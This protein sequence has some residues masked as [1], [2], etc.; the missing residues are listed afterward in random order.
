MTWNPISKIW[1]VIVV[2]VRE[3]IFNKTGA[4]AV[5]AVMGH[6]AEKRKECPS[7]EIRRK[8]EKR[9]KKKIG[10]AHPGSATS[11]ELSVPVPLIRNDPVAA[12]RKDI[13]SLHILAGKSISVEKKATP[14]ITKTELE[15]PFA[16]NSA[17]VTTP[18]IST[19]TTARSEESVE[20]E[21]D[22]HF[23]RRSRSAGPATA[24]A[25]ILSTETRWPRRNTVRSGTAADRRSRSAS[26]ILV[27]DA[28]APV[29]R[30]G[31]SGLKEFPRRTREDAKKLSQA[32][33]T[34]SRSCV[35]CAAHEGSRPPLTLQVNK[36]GNQSS[37]TPFRI[38]KFR[39]LDLPVTLLSFYIE[40][41]LNFLLPVD[42][43]PL[44][45][46][47]LSNHPSAFAVQNHSQQFFRELKISNSFPYKYVH[48]NY[49]ILPPHVRMHAHH[50][51]HSIFCLI[52][53][54]EC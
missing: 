36:S 20:V 1:L 15:A 2:T 48:D 44:R 38:P 35:K 51:T 32:T 28:P 25:A 22:N 27:T 19:S 9:V 29:S 46:R 3:F 11:T 23:R 53:A 41:R 30:K 45:V 6:G 49:Y 12:L 21:V 50:V 37:T 14:T 10:V 34:S 13:T 31:L 18:T 24:A 52:L 40:L 8:D 33:P 5:S 7:I 17:L 47:V 54:L 16:K 39:A 26:G 42:A 4:L 43:K